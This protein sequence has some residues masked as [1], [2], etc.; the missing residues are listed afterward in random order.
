MRYLIG[1]LIILGSCSTGVDMPKEKTE[2]FDF[3]T[4]KKKLVLP[5]ILHEIS[6]LVAL[7]SNVAACVQDEQGVV[8]FLDL[9]KAEIIDQMEFSGPGDFEGIAQV[10]SSLF[11]LQSDGILF[12]WKNFEQREKEILSYPTP[13]PATN[14]E[15]LCYDKNS[16]RILIGCKSKIGKGKEFKNLRAIYAFDLDTKELSEKPVFEF[17]VEAVKAFAREKN[18]PLPQRE[19]PKNKEMMDVL[20]FQISAI[21]IHPITND[22]YILSATDHMLFVC[23]YEG[24]L[25]DIKVLDPKTFNKAEGIT[26]LENGDMW[27]TN[28]GQDA[29]PTLLFFKN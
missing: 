1:L 11:M 7:D 18:I 20:K 15:G 22:L 19:H 25:Q 9:H 6:G 14:N 3:N 23:S 2:A 28:E 27:I 4:P 16:N 26:I 21:A 8:F 17:D 13:I 12:E 29:K 5:D 10:G 24:I